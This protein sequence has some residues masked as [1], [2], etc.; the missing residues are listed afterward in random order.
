MLGGCA[1]PLPSPSASPVVTEIQLTAASPTTRVTLPPQRAAVFELTLTKV[2]NPR[3]QSFAIH[4]VLEVLAADG[5]TAM[6]DLGTAAPFPADQPSS[7]QLSIPTR[8]QAALD[9]QPRSADAVLT[10]VPT[11]DGQR[12]T[13]PLAVAA[14]IKVA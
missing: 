7:F 4:V 12:L 3:L 6:F 13:D 8:A 2:E 5:A 1:R 14:R 9:A 10:L 11:T